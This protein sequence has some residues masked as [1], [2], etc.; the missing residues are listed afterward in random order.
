MA[1]APKFFSHK[2][3][4]WLKDLGSSSIDDV[5][6][7]SPAAASPDLRVS[8]LAPAG[9]HLFAM[10][11][12]D[13]A[14]LLLS[15]RPPH[16]VAR[17][18]RARLGEIWQIC[19]FPDLDCLAVLE[20]PNPVQESDM[21]PSLNSSSN[22]GG[23]VGVYH[24]SSVPGYLG[25]LA[26]SGFELIAG[27]DI[28]HRLAT[29]S[30]EKITIWQFPPPPASSARGIK[31]RTSLPRVLYRVRPL[32]VP[33]HLCIC[34]KY[35]AYASSEEV[36]VTRITVRKRTLAPHLDPRHAASIPLHAYQRWRKTN[37]M[38]KRASGGGMDEGQGVPSLKQ[39]ERLV[40]REAK[41]GDGMDFVFDMSS[42]LV[43]PPPPTRSSRRHVRFR[44]PAATS[45]R[46]KSSTSTSTSVF[47]RGGVLVSA[48]KEGDHTVYGPYRDYTQEVIGPQDQSIGA[49]GHEEYVFDIDCIL[50]HR[51]GDKEMV[52][53]IDFRSVAAPKSEKPCLLISTPSA[54]RLFDVGDTSILSRYNFGSGLI[55]AKI[56]PPY[57]VAL[58]KSTL[59]IHA[60]WRGH[61]FPSSTL[62]GPMLLWAGDLPKCHWHS[63][64]ETICRLAITGSTL[65]LGAGTLDHTHEGH[66]PF[67]AFELRNAFCKGGAGGGKGGGSFAI[68]KDICFLGIE[69]IGQICETMVSGGGLGRLVQ[70]YMLLNTHLSTCLDDRP[71]QQTLRRICGE[72]GKRLVLEDLTLSVDLFA[73]SDVGPKEVIE[74]IKRVTAEG[75]RKSEGG[76]SGWDATDLVT[77]YV[78]HVLLHPNSYIKRLVLESKSITKIIIRHITQNMP[79][80][81][82][83]FLLRTYLFWAPLNR[84]PLLSI[85]QPPNPFANH[86]PPTSE[87]KH[88]SSEPKSSSESRTYPPESKFLRKS[89]GSAGSTPLS[90][91]SPSIKGGGLTEAMAYLLIAV[92]ENQYRQAKAV[93]D[94]LGDEGEE[95]LRDVILSRPEIVVG[96]KVQ[97]KPADLASQNAALRGK[98]V[99]F[100]RIYAPFVLVDI[101]T[102]LTVHGLPTSESV[103]PLIEPKEESKKLKPR[104][105]GPGERIVKITLVEAKSILLTNNA[106]AKQKLSD[107][108]DDKSNVTT[109]KIMKQYLDENQILWWQ[110]LEGCFAFLSKKNSEKYMKLMEEVVTGLV[111]WYLTCLIERKKNDEAKTKEEKGSLGSDTSL[112]DGWLVSSK[113]RQSLDSFL[114]L[115]YMSKP[116]ADVPAIPQWVRATVPSSL[117]RED[118]HARDKLDLRPS[119]EN[120]FKS[121]QV[122]EPLVI[123]PLTGILA[124][125]PESNHSNPNHKGSKPTTNSA[126][127]VKASMEA[128]KSNLHNPSRLGADKLLKDVLKVALERLIRILLSDLPRRPKEIYELMENVR[129]ESA[130]GWKRPV[131][132]LAMPGV[133]KIV[134]GCK[135]LVKDN[136]DSLPHFAKT[137][138]TQP[139]DWRA[140]LSLLWTE[141]H[142]KT[143]RHIDQPS[144]TPSSPPTN[145]SRP[146][147]FP[148]S[149]AP[150]EEEGEGI[151]GAYA[152]ILRHLCWILPPDEFLDALPEDGDIRYFLQYI[153]DSCAR[154]YADRTIREMGNLAKTL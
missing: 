98:V 35:I 60:L 115:P 135:M 118:V 48:R 100:L 26:E 72:L 108:A 107:S 65:L 154:L 80:M 69:E 97:G 150:V 143:P 146:P 94:V 5:P 113:F 62:P 31:K 8:A 145:L 11:T 54:A 130:A 140:I 37:T 105:L 90:P 127:G 141:M 20:R 92:A 38:K 22:R 117:L 17:K 74:T 114:R 10:G 147:D 132:V 9:P 77:R 55:T 3:L 136:V 33:R 12:T 51:V 120:D 96:P 23:V 134:E 103:S 111:L 93:L 104:F 40:A 63:E 61:P 144:L 102:H 89:S 88:L 67:A 2:T 112:L 129:E 30:S 27:C 49:Q 1:S 116:L 79:K 84:P 16:R 109:S 15:R 99:N 110:Y 68:M 7:D 138:A 76:R 13:R 53:G 75:D 85:L 42:N 64:G 139:A 43:Q 52:A 151:L 133:G 66:I 50:V 101:L 126:A 149:P 19:A 122:S 34:G 28:S 137:F 29:Y 87:S 36:H 131:L 86:K 24:I 119:P 91:L 44:S 78:T 73:Q 125:R 6:S 83:H 57:V 81:L 45:S 14:L 4:R 95:A 123:D 56:H 121:T 82:S 25:R 152:R 71:A 47:S 41:S 59:Q 18:M 153:Q 124:T 32:C 128:N 46:K 142:P 21:S 148:G 39:R 106:K 58:T 70:A